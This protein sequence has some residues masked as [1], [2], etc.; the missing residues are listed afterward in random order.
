M[1]WEGSGREA[2]PYP[3]SH[4]LAGLAASAASRALY[5]PLVTSTP[6]VQK[7]TIILAAAVAQKPN[8]G[9]HTW[10]FLQYLLGFKRLGYNVLLIDRLEPDTPQTTGRAAAGLSFLD[11][12]LS[13]FGL[14]GPYSIL[15]DGNRTLGLSRE[16]VIAKATQSAL[17]INVMGF[18]RDEEILSAAK[19]KAYLDIDP[20]FPQMWKVNGLHDS[21]IGHD[22]YVTVGREIGSPT[23]LVPT[24]GLNWIK[25][26]PPVVLDQWPQS[27]NVNGPI[28]S[29]ASWRGAYGP[30][31]Y[32]GQTFGL[33]VHEFR[34]FMQLPLAV[35]EYHPMFELALDIHAAESR[36]IE[37][38]NHNG[39]ILAD[40]RAVAGDIH[41]YRN[42]LA[43]SSAE[44]CVA[45]NMYVQANTGWFSDRSACYLA[46][47]KPVIAQE[48]GWS[49]YYPAGSGLLTFTTL[50]QAA[51]AVDSICSDPAKHSQSAREIACEYFDSDKVL[52]TLLSD[53]GIK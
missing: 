33:R 1:V 24:C 3:D 20:G 6:S 2:A 4:R 23:C 45:K 49:N 40:P 26:A 16:E 7:K 18:L 53:L 51:A 48:T 32:N 36:D 14:T 15:L 41:S 52:P 17:L 10:V 29:V 44:F 28:T 46:S 34:K 31:D 47:G 25:I 37:A 27:T 5:Q 19:L 50:D 11:Q 38:L 8:H 42:Y 22:A 43:R 21:L 30:V 12:C 9:G 39:W 13:S 35:R